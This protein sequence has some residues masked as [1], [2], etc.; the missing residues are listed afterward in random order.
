MNEDSKTIGGIIS[1]LEEAVSLIES[2]NGEGGDDYQSQS[3]VTD[4]AETLVRRAIADFKIAQIA[5]DKRQLRR[6]KP[7]AAKAEL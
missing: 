2:A 5:I 3:T 1:A 6:P 4:R 7:K